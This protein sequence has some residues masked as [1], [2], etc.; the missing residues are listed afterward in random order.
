MGHEVTERPVE[1]PMRL[2]NDGQSRQ[3][4][5]CRSEST[6]AVMRLSLDGTSPY[7]RA[8]VLAKNASGHFPP[9]ESIIGG[10]GIPQGLLNLH[11]AY[12][13]ARSFHGTSAHRQA[14]T[15][16]NNSIESLIGGRGI[17]QEFSKT[18]ERRK[19]AIAQ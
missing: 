4:F 8:C 15:I 10:R 17:L 18:F 3:G 13:S 19:A 1:S 12:G 7:H 2:R 14:C 6:S 5:A 11:R 16:T 9:I